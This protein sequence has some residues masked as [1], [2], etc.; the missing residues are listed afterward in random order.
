MAPGAASLAAQGLALVTN[1]ACGGA[2]TT[3]QNPATGTKVTTWPALRAGPG[4]N[5]DRKSVV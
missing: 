4:Q 2:G 5:S 1:Y 3:Y